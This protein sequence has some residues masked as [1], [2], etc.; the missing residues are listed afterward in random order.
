MRSKVFAVVLL[1]VPFGVGIVSCKAR[2]FNS[3]SSVKAFDFKDSLPNDFD[4]YGYKEKTRLLMDRVRQSEVKPIPD[5]VIGGDKG[6]LAKFIQDTMDFR[7][8]PASSIAALGIFSRLRD[9]YPN[10]V[11]FLGI[12]VKHRRLTHPVGA[13]GVVRFKPRKGTP[14]T[15]LFAEEAGAL[16]IARVS[17]ATNPHITKVMNRAIAIKFPVT[18]SYSRSLI[19]M[20]RVIG[21]NIGPEQNPDI[22]KNIN[23]FPEKIDYNF[24]KAQKNLTNILPVG[25]GFE[26]RIAGK[27]ADITRYVRTSLNRPVNES[28]ESVEGH[29]NVD[30]DLMSRW[31]SVENMAWNSQGGAPVS[32]PKAPARVTLV[33]NT[34]LYNPVWQEKHDFRDSLGSIAPGTLLFTVYG[35]D[36]ARSE[37]D[38]IVR[39]E[40]VIGEIVLEEKFEKGSFANEGLMFKHFVAGLHTREGLEQ[41][42]RENGEVPIENPGPDA[43]DDL[44][45]LNAATVPTQ[46]ISCEKVDATLI[47]SDKRGFLRK[48][49]VGDKFD[50]VRSET[51]PYCFLNRKN[52]APGWPTQLDGV[53]WMKGNTMPDVLLNFANAEFNRASN[54]ITVSVPG[55]FTFSFHASPSKGAKRSWSREA[56]IALHEFT[57]ALDVKYEFEFNPTPGSSTRIIPILRGVGVRRADLVDF[58]FFV[59]EQ[60]DAPRNSNELSDVEQVAEIEEPNMEALP[61]GE[62]KE[63]TRKSSFLRRKMNDYEFLKVVQGDGTPVAENYSAYLEDMRQKGLAFQAFYRGS[64]K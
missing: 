29:D 12:P 54:K 57:K 5:V 32:S 14:Y 6:R 64:K 38:G 44:G 4:S 15:G 58:T 35:S 48:T 3:I 36:D 10:H 63:L 19:A 45:P 33:P 34:D 52:R 22:K 28:G 16:G 30:I 47:A 59:P 43:T 39:S 25:V 40:N 18:G 1:S 37:R 50:V 7:F 26:A 49:R 56:G 31:M 51:A 42:F 23:G 20:H 27:F 55:P 2:Q 11:D 41:K 13:V 21:Q 61:E 24:F 8:R 62:L 17:T 46:E 53:W 60:L 9:V